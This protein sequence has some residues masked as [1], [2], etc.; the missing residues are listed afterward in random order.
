MAGE[1]KLLTEELALAVRDL[2]REHLRN[3]DRPPLA[4]P[5]RPRGRAPIRAI[6]LQDL[7]DG[8]KADA[9]LTRL[10]ETNEIQKISIV[11]D[12][13]SGGTFKLKFKNQETSSLNFNCSAAEMQA[14]LEALS[15][16][17]KGNVSVA[18]GKQDYINDVTLTKATEFP[19]VWLVQFQGALAADLTLPLLTVTK[20]L[21]GGPAVI[22]AATEFYADSGVVET[23]RALVPVGTPTPM[24]AG[25]VA[26]GLWFPGIG[27]G[28]IACECRQFSVT[29]Y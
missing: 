29:Y 11:G 17:G 9:A 23:L 14:A 4:P 12:V 24:K 15:T 26:I 2:V 8:G 7:A 28:V 19:G 21:Q 20:S 5:H 22:V 3:P 25:A 1:S 6:L 18:L 13:V 16:I 27:Y 10:E